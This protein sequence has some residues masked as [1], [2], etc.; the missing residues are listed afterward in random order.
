MTMGDDTHIQCR[1]VKGDRT[2]VS[3]LPSK[4]ATVG[5]V[6]KLSDGRTGA[7]DDGW[8]VEETYSAMETAEANERSRDHTRTR[9][10][11][12]VARDGN[13]EKIKDK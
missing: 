3:W 12:D 10:A 13:R 8:V 2:Q 7:W 4:F 5:R 9:K 1:L 6:V 11:S